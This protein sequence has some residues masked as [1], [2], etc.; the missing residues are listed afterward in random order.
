MLANIPNWPCLSLGISGSQGQA[1]FSNPHMRLPVIFF[2]QRRDSVISV[3]YVTDLYVVLYI[4][5]GIYLKEVAVKPYPA[6]PC[7][8]IM[9]LQ[10]LRAF[11][12]ASPL[13]G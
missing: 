3:R 13:S 4:V 11:P 9:L 10:P 6:V 8:S 2:V 7:Q 5:L 1:S 12:P